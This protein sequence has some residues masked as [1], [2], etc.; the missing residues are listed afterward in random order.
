M[1]IMDEKL[2]LLQTSGFFKGFSGNI[3]NMVAPRLEEC[4]FS[5]N[6]IVCMKDDESDCLY[7]IRQGQ[8]EITV[9]SKDGK[10]IVLGT[11]ERG[12]VVG[13]IGLLDKGKRTANVTAKT[14]VSLYRLTSDD[15][16]KISQNFTLR[17][18]LAI[19]G[20]IC[21]LFRRVTHNLEDTVFL[22]ASA[23]VIRKVLEICEKDSGSVKLT[24]SQEQLGRMVGLSREATNKTL[25]RLEDIGLLERKYK[26]I[27]VPDVQKLREF[28]Q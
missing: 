23:R 18:W 11:L 24:I 3:L 27:T 28:L 15:F 12:D 8:V 20:Y 2:A 21:Q 14:D 4:R 22:D 9:S 16:N 6:N 1:A 10:I 19:N 26:T 5:K 7:V 13:E 17:E 25:S